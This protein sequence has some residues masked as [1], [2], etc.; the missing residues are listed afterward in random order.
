M[1]VGVVNQ[2]SREL[3]RG[4]LKVG[5]VIL[6]GRLGVQTALVLHRRQGKVQERAVVIGQGRLA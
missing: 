5:G 6:G 2:T 1:P 4:L 3:A